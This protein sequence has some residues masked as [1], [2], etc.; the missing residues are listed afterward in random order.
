[1]PNYSIA[2]SDLITYILLV[3]NLSSNTPSYSKAL[4]LYLRLITTL[5]NYISKNTNKTLT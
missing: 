3:I 4:L 5:T 1:M 2:S